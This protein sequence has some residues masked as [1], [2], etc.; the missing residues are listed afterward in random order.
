MQDTLPKPKRS[1]NFETFYAFSL[2]WQLGF[3]IAVPIAA[4]IGIGFWLDTKFNTQ[5]LFVL[6]GL[7]VGLS[8]TIYEVYHVMDPLIKKDK[9]DA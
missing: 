2:A 9:K 4:F 1:K 3:L 8:V 5:P 6:S 7:V